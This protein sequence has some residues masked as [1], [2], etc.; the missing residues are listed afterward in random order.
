M[1]KQV[2]K[3]I[4]NPYKTE[5]DIPEGGIIRHVGEQYGEVCVWVE[6]DPRAEKETRVIEAFGTGHTLSSEYRKYIGSV[7]LEGGSLIFH[8]YEYPKEEI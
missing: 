1:E 3:Y 2:W 8:L 4:I 7:S 6:V 5:Y